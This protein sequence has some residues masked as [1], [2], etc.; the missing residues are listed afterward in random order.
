MSESKPTFS[1]ASSPT[2]R[3][4]GELLGFVVSGRAVEKGG[5]AIAEPLFEELVAAECVG[6]DGFGDVFPA[7][8]GVEVDVEET[9]AAG[10][11]GG[12]AGTGHDG[13][14]EAAVSPAGGDGEVGRLRSADLIVRIL[15][16]RSWGCTGDSQVSGV[17]RTF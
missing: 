10:A 7:G 4:V 8:G 12:F 11:G 2:V 1:S 14:G 9:L 16:F 5:L 3:T 15:W 13:S 17:H 6:P